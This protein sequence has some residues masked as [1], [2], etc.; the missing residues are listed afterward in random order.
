MDQNQ[1]EPVKSKKPNIS[2]QLARLDSMDIGPEL[3]KPH[4]FSSS[5]K[6]TKTG[7]GTCDE[8]VGSANSGNIT[9]AGSTKLQMPS[10]PEEK[11]V[12]F[13]GF[14]VLSP[15]YSKIGSTR[16]CSKKEENNWAL[17]AQMSKGSS[18]QILQILSPGNASHLDL[19]TNQF[20][21]SRNF[22]MFA[23]LRNDGKVIRRIMEIDK[24]RKLLNKQ[25]DFGRT[26][27]HYA[28]QFKKI[29]SVSVLLSVGADPSIQDQQGRTAF[30]LAAMK[31]N[32]DLFLKLMTHNVN[33]K[34]RD[35]FQRK[36]LSYVI[37]VK[38]R[39]LAHT[40]LERAIPSKQKEEGHSDLVQG[41]TFVSDRSPRT[42][43]HNSGLMLALSSQKEV[44][45]P[46]NSS[47]DPSTVDDN[48]EEED[49]LNRFSNLRRNYYT[50]LRIPGCRPIY[51]QQVTPIVY[52]DKYNEVMSEKYDREHSHSPSPQKSDSPTNKGMID[53][54][55]L[56][57]TKSK[58]VGIA[59]FA[60]EDML[61]SGSFGEVYCVRMKSTAQLFAMKVFSK[62]QILGSSI[63]RFLQIEKKVMM[64]YDHPFLVRLHYTFQSPRK[65]FLVMDLCIKKDLGKQ[66]KAMGTL[67]ETRCK[68]LMAELVLAIE[69]LHT[70]NII[71]R[72]LK[73]DNILIAEDGH[74]KLTDFG[75]CKELNQSNP[76]TQTFCGSLSYLPP[77]V[78]NRTGHNKSLDWYLIGQVLYECVVGNP[79]FIDKNR[80]LVLEKIKKGDLK[81]PSSVS[82]VC[83][84]LI[85]KLMCQ[86]MSPRLG[87][88]RGATEIKEH[89]FFLGLDW[90]RV[91]KKEYQL[92]ESQEVK[93]Y[94]INYYNQD[95][96][97]PTLAESNID[98]PFWTFCEN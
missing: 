17:L 4:Q 76:M 93:S 25:D 72:D 97:A 45:I 19:F 26:A 49:Y 15:K 24:H 32:T 8:K 3:A 89:P 64:N 57:P 29:E 10:I 82:A 34:L 80:E 85:Q 33:Q 28:V 12:N 48:Q 90:T 95:I 14:A 59:D 63:A 69:A 58:E 84:D 20:E 83:C 91:Y 18:S 6:V 52:K 38:L 31:N 44:T 51:S 1:S 87:S 71:H 43:R 54:Q 22:L 70:K 67:R 47:N 41:S 65:L 27:L 62:R 37:D 50:A 74:I 23:A 86:D 36:A 35:L 7:F 96:P 16:F 5:D 77:E 39:K 78:V 61:G 9:P 21:H 53:L 2:R 46:T 30:H 79:P 11:S 13:H 98:L 60:L 68:I 73:P 94:E 55:K 42:P 40:F 92:F 56:S 88:K 75:L 66:L 81:I